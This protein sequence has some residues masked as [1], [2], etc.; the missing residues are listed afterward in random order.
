MAATLTL[1]TLR[2]D[3]ARALALLT[4]AQHVADLEE[5][6]AVPH[7]QLAEPLLQLGALEYNTVRRFMNPCY[8]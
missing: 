7:C 4:A 1:G 2:F 8:Y 5:M 6:A 3:E